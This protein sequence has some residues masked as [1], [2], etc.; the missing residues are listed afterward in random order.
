[1]V[2]TFALSAD[3]IRRDVAPGRGGCLATDEVTVK[4]LG[5]N[6]MYREEPDDDLD[7]GWRYFSGTESQ[8]YVD[9]PRNLEI[10]E[11]NTIAN[12]SPDIVAWLDTPPGAAFE[13]GVDGVLR[14]I[15]DF[16]FRPTEE[17]RS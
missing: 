6:F 15:D 10:Y 12:Y 2:K 3:Q 14:P 1:M 11:V 4:G 17:E 7:S 5:V 16:P 8:G 9:D 13:R